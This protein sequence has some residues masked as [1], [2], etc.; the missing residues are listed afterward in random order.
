MKNNVNTSIY[1]IIHTMVTETIDSILFKW[2]NIVSSPKRLTMIIMGWCSI[3]DI[4]DSSND[5][6]LNYY[7][8][9]RSRY[10][11]GWTYCKACS[12]YIT[13]LNTHYYTNYTTFFRKLSMSI[14]EDIP[15]SFYRKSSNPKIVPYIE[16]NGYYTPTPY[17]FIYENINTHSINVSISWNECVKPISLSNLIF[18]NRSIFGYEPSEFP[19]QNIPTLIVSL[20]HSHYDHCKEWYVLE[21][22]FK[23]Y[24]FTNTHIPDI[25]QHTIFNYW[26]NLFIL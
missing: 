21:C 4:T 11:Y 5:I 10:L 25:I 2:D 6:C 15:L 12:P 18:Y 22:I 20:L 13:L 17:D 24:S 23:H 3:C 7:D 1:S 16:H 26:N 14:F 8:T 9:P 19:I